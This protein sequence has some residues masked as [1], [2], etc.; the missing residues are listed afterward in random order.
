MTKMFDNKKLSRLGIFIIWGAVIL[1]YSIW[2]V[3][4]IYLPYGRKR[5]SLRRQIIA[6][7][8][9]IGQKDEKWRHYK[10][11]E[12]RLGAS[13]NTV[14]TIR[15]KLPELKNLEKIVTHLK[16]IGIEHDLVIEEEVPESYIGLQHYPSES[17]I[18]PV[19][20]TFRLKGNFEAIG[21][22]IQFLDEENK[23][24]CH[25]K[26]VNMER[27]TSKTYTVSALIKMEMF[28]QKQKGK[29]HDVL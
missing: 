15:S 7:E 3:I 1:F 4:V 25:I 24:F 27:S 21:R 23:Q 13:M 9:E 29:N 26:S 11:A 2:W 12:E 10:N 28:F 14:Q 5:E 6:L 16:D 22:F 17:L 8:Q 20:L 18:H 19:N